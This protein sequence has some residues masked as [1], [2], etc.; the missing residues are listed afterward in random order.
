MTFTFGPVVTSET[1]ET[2]YIYIYIYTCILHYAYIWAIR[3]NA[4][5][6]TLE[7]RSE[8]KSKVFSL[9]PCK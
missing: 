3:F 8:A 6:P 7:C 2:L 5:I 9:L 4:H 1:I